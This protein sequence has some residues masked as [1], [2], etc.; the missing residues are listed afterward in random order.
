MRKILVHEQ[1]AVA[2]LRLGAALDED[3]V[4]FNFPGDGVS[5]RTGTH[6]IGDVTMI[7]CNTC[8]D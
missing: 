2:L 3:D 6:M 5:L 4:G 8:S 1:L 7:T